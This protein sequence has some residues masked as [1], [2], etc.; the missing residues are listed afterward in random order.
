MSDAE[1][2][3]PAPRAQADAP[4]HCAECGHYNE[5]E[6]AEC[7]VCHSHLWVGCRRCK[8]KTL[9][10]AGRCA[11]C[12]KQLRSGLAFSWP[13]WRLQ[14]RRKKTRRILRA[15]LLLTLLGGAAF[16]LY[17]ALPEADR[18]VH[19]PFLFP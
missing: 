10:S 3:P 17:R 9:R 18:P 15:L 13:R 7:S 4:I 14:I 1:P 8:H 16:V 19:R 12:H 11:K 2:I 6:A 5:R